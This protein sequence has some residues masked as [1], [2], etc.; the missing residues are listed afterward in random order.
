MWNKIVMKLPY[1]VGDGVGFGVVGDGVG[2][3]GAGVGA[4]YFKYKMFNYLQNSSAKQ[5]VTITWSSSSTS[6]THSNC[7]EVIIIIITTLIWIKII[8]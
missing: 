5:L 7:S 2:I 3:V 8:V 6:T 1:G 4:Q